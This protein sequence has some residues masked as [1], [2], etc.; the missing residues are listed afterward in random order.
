MKLTKEETA[1]VLAALRMWQA[2]VVEEDS[3]PI[4]FCDHFT[5]VL[6][7]TTEEID[8]LC[9]KINLGEEA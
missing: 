9:E 5:D 2:D 7:L 1:T 6:P 4:D 8:A 3:F